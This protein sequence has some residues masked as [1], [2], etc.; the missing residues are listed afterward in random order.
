M[1]QITETLC[2]T[3][4]SNSTV[5]ALCQQSDPAVQAFRERPLSR[6]YPLIIVDAIYTKSREAGAVRSKGLLIAMCVNEH[7]LREVLGFVTGDGESYETWS[8]FFQPLKQR[9][10]NDV[11]LVVSDNHSGRVRAIKEHVHGAMRQRCQTHFSRNLLDKVSARQRSDIK[12]RLK[13]LYNSPDLEE[14]WRRHESLLDLLE[15]VAPEAAAVLDSGFDDI[16][17]VFNLPEAYRKRLRTS[18]SIERLNEEIRRRE[19][20]IRI[21]PNEAS[22]NCLIGSLLLEQH[23]CWIS[24]KAYFTMDGYYLDKNKARAAAVM[25]RQKQGKVA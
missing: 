18:N 2:G 10:L 3:S 12:T 7:E 25:I 1:S 5:S 23:E 15:P 22:I 21:F 19:R 6:A 20:V 14:A 8:I 16:T 17:A 11:D 24:G 9:G 4:F 13:D